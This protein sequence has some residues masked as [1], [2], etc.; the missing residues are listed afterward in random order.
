MSK[1]TTQELD[2]ASDPTI[3]LIKYRMMEKVW[4]FLE[5]LQKEIK[6]RLLPFQSKL[7]EQLKLHNGKISKGENYKRL[8]YMILDYPAHFTREDI[9][10][11]RIMFY[12][13]HFISATFHL[14]G[15]YLR[16]F[17]NKLIEEFQED[18]NVFFCVNSEPWD[19]HYRSNNYMLL[20]DLNQC[21]IEEHVAG[22]D[23]IKLSI[24]FP[25]EE[26][27]Q[28]KSNLINFL[29]LGLKVIQTN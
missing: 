20:K 3:L 4:D 28:R 22:T 6:D 27:P 13:G 14:Q 8:P 12:W 15:K 24:K 11:F 21:D 9:L 23:F 2:L 25:V 19:Y 10:A 17:G 29:D 7:P 26:M 18:E 5:E 16:E 1:F